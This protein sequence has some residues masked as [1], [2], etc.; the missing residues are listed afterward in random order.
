MI[1]LTKH[2]TQAAYDAVKD[3]LAKP[4]VALIAENNSVAYQPLTPPAPP[5]IDGHEYVEIGGIKWATMNVGANSVTDGGLYFQ[6]GDTQGY[7]ADQAGVDKSFSENDYKWTEDGGQTFTKYNDEDGL[8]TLQASDDAVTAAWGSNWRM[9]TLDE[10]LRLSTAVTSAYTADYE[11]SGVAGVVLTS[12]ADS[13]KKLFF[14]FDGY[15]NYDNISSTNS[16]SACWTSTLQYDTQGYLSGF[17]SYL[18][19]WGND[20]DYFSYGRYYGYNVRGVVNE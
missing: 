13:S 1:Y 6:W 9:P 18:I 12:N 7:T 17:Y 4:Q 2:S 5:I 20:R 11:G 19:E 10:I 15:G 3:N 8:T 14:P 16:C